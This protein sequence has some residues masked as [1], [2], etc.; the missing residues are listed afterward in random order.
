[1]NQ[2]TLTLSDEEQTLLN[3]LA[4]ERGLDTPEAVLRTLLYDAV[5]IYDALWDKK[6]A[7]SQDLLDRLADDAHAEYR[8]GRT[9][10]FDPD[11]DPDAP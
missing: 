2:I 7:E 3:T 9:E 6:F 5:Q 10:D 4:Q 1:M 8:A 11:N